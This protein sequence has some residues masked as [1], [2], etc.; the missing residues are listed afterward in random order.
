MEEIW[1]EIG[2]EG[3][4]ISTCGRVKDKNG[5]F[6]LTQKDPEGYVR[7]TI[8]GFKR[9]RIHRAMAL[10]FLPN[11][12]N[13]NIVDHIDRNKE[14]NVL[15]NL[16]WVSAS[17]N[18]ANAIYKEGRLDHIIGMNIKTKEIKEFIN[19]NEAS[20]YI[21]IKRGGS[22]GEVNKVL[23]HKRKTTHGW[24]FWYKQDYIK[25]HPDYI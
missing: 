15:N 20:L 24:T 13:Y 21:G 14:N 11:P 25:E 9:E 18:A 16:R 5:N 1:K 17:E 6:I 3:A 22:S 8:P 19:Q 4:M 7:C 10:I 12:N 23:H 2:I